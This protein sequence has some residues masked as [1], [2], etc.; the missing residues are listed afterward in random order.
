M[1]TEAVTAGQKLYCRIT[2]QT[3]PFHRL[4]LATVPSFRTRWWSQSFISHFK[5][6]CIC[7]ILWQRWNR[8]MWSSPRWTTEPC[9]RNGPLPSGSCRTYCQGMSRQVNFCATNFVG[10]F[11]IAEIWEGALPGITNTN[12]TGFVTVG[13]AR[14]DCVK[15]PFRA[16]MFPQE[17]PNKAQLEVLKIAL[18]VRSSSLDRT[19]IS[20]FPVNHHHADL[21][22]A[23][24]R[25]WQ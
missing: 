5:Y 2:E 10:F 21:G 7:T 23:M 15:L 3:F 20:N 16:D 11:S 8:K 12:V 6:C 14:N 13:M 24:R 18:Y 9:F 1:R 19:S 17:V 25:G 4:H 22:N